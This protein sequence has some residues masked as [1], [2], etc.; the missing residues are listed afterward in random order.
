MIS[1]QS[2]LD[3]SSKYVLDDSNTPAIQ[4]GRMIFHTNVGDFMSITNDFVT[5]FVRNFKQDMTVSCFFESQEEQHL[6]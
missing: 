6:E 1:Q 5:L 2:L 3:K 4:E